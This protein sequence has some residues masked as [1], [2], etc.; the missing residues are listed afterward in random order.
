MPHRPIEVNPGSPISRPYEVV[1]TD[2]GTST[3]REPELVNK[4]SEVAWRLVSTQGQTDLWDG[5]RREADK[6]RH[7]ERLS[8]HTEITV[9]Y[10]FSLMGHSI[11]TDAARLW[12]PTHSESDITDCLVDLVKSSCVVQ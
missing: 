1:F 3:F 7:R 4:A 10:R 9:A 6:L 5:A 11:D 8:S 12:V 2:R